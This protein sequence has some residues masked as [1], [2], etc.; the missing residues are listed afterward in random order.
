[1]R[2]GLLDSKTSLMGDI[3]TDR[4]LLTLLEGKDCLLAMDKFFVFLE[5][6]AVL[7]LE[8]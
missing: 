4:T 1:M 3:L 5:L 2:L 8:I 6:Q 7:T